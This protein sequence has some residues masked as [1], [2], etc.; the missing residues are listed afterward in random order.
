MPVP[1]DGGA[2]PMTWVLPTVTSASGPPSRPTPT[3]PPVAPCPAE[4]DTASRGSPGWRCGPGARPP[5]PQD[6][7]PAPPDPAPPD[8]APPESQVGEPPDPLGGPFGDPP[9]S[10]EGGAGEPAGGP[11]EAEVEV[12]GWADATRRPAADREAVIDADD[13]FHESD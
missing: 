3:T 2:S 13:A 9:G 12:L 4:T 10:D 7:D 1:C 6:P 5:E 11:P 8:P